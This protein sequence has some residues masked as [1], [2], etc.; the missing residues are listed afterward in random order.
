MPMVKN[1]KDDIKKSENI[2]VS[3][4][5]FTVHSIKSENAK[6]SVEQIIKNLILN[7]V[8]ELNKASLSA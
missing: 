2:E 4:T 5:I 1:K 6:K 3:G 7:N 8:D